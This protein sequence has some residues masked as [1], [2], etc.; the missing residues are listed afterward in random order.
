MRASVRRWVT[1]LALSAASIQPAL[2][3]PT[4]AERCVAGKMQAVGT[5]GQCRLRAGAK[6]VKQNMVADFGKCDAVFDKAF[7]KLEGKFACTTV[8]DLESWRQEIIAETVKVGDSLLFPLPLGAS[9]VVIPNLDATATSDPILELTNLGPAPVLAQCVYVRDAP[10]QTTD[11]IVS[12]PGY[13]GVAWSANSGLAMPQLIP[14]VP[15]SPF[16]GDMVCVAISAPETPIAEDV[17]AAT[18]FIPGHAG[19]TSGLHIRSTATNDGDTLLTLGGGGE[20]LACP[21]SIPVA[22]IEGCWSAGPFTFDCN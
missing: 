3:R 18:V 12:V 20:Y 1:G 14:P 2:A 11:F 9:I 22:R 15:A 8:G 10:C 6:A 19:S 7:Q 4:D 21:A 16:R 17:L 13:G 5:Y